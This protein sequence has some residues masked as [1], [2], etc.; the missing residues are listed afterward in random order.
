[1]PETFHW[2]EG[3]AL[4]RLAAVLH[5]PET[6]GPHPAVLFCH[7]FTGTKVEPKRLFLT[8]A[9]RLLRRGLAV[10]RFDFGG[11]GESE[12][13]FHDLTLGGELTD[14]RAAWDYLADHAGVDRERRAL[15]GFSLGGWAAATLA[16][17][18]RP[19]AL[20][21]WAPVGDPAGMKT[22]LLGLHGLETLEGG[23]TVDVAGDALGPAF[24]KDF[25]A[26]AGKVPGGGYAGPTLL[27]H[28]SQDEAVDAATA[29][30]YDRVLGGPGHP[31]EKRILPGARHLFET[32]PHRAALYD[33]TEAFLARHLGAP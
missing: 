30:A 29:E 27:L 10:L 7:G 21:L 17:L 25:P 32:V 12:G 23:G 13:A 33:A 20:A 22:R 5:L 15:L 9:R 31:F 2:I 8:F 26:H 28:G 11:H 4:G 6:S 16:P 14:A 3:G 1:V 24:A 18:L 19:A